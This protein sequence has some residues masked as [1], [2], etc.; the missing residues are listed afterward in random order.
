[1]QSPGHDATPARHV[2]TVPPVE[3]EDYP[4]AHAAAARE[5]VPPPRPDQDPSPPDWHVP[6]EALQRDWSEAIER[7]QQTGEPLFYAKGYMDM[8]PRIQALAE[9]PDIPAKSRAP[10]IEALE[11]H[12]RDL[13]ARRYVEDCL[14]AAE[15]HMDT[16]ASLL[17]A[18]GSL[19]IPIV[20]VSE[21]QGWRQE[22]ARLA[23]AA[24][25]ILADSDTYGAHL[26]NIETGRTRVERELSR[27]RRAS[28]EDGEYA[29]EQKKPQLHGKSADT[30]EKVEQA[31]P[32][33]P[34][35]YAPY[36][37][38]RQ[39][40]N[41]LI[42][43]ARQAGIPSILRQGLHGHDPAHPGACGEPGYPG[44]DTGAPDPGA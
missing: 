43:D 6:Y 8:I 35:W 27:L 21:H 9:N 4:R 44:Q 25:T 28:R 18:A 29:A 24:E 14:A 7:V 31:E 37:A 1:M 36:M 39:D 23:A 16:H 32:L 38:M 22:A 41:S 13:S 30:P 2:D 19:G 10:M 15:R 20:E 42:E 17:R 11:N 3:A 26:D 34:A 12:Q 40:W 33:K 5:H